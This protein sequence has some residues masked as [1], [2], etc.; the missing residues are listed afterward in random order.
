MEWYRLSSLKDGDILELQPKK[1]TAK[2]RTSIWDNKN[3]KFINQGE[4][5]NT[6]LGMQEVNRYTR[7]SDEEKKYFNKSIKM[8][9]EVVIDGRDTM[10]SLSTKANKNLQEQ[11]NAVREMG[12]E[13]LEF[14]YRLKREGTGLKTEYYVSI[15]KEVGLPSGVKKETII[16]TKLDLTDMEKKY[17]NALKTYPDAQDYSNED[18]VNVLISKLGISE[19][20][21]RKIVNENW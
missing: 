19:D 12:K 16:V 4:M 2:E 6:E 18:R 9:R 20:R 3:R 5:I 21:A 11:M 13:P 8:I 14:T 7:L 1:I 10:I 15:G 17:L